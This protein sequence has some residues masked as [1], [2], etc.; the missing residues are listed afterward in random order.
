VIFLAAPVP[1][2]ELD[3]ALT[4]VLGIGGNTSVFSVVNAALL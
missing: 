1:D 4:P 2:F 3:F